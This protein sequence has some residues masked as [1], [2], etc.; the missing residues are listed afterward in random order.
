[1]TNI[2]VNESTI[3]S[4]VNS[5]HNNLVLESNY[6]N[7]TMKYISNN[8]TVLQNYEKTYIN[9]TFNNIKA[10]DVF[11]NDTMNTVDTNVTL[12]QTYTKTYLNAT[13]NNIKL[14]ENFIN[15]TL[16]SFNLNFTSKINILNTSIN[17]MNL[18]QSSYFNIVHSIV[19]NINFNATQRYKMEEVA[20]TFAYHFV[21]KSESLL[22]NG[23]DITAWLE[24]VAGQPVNSTTLVKSVWDNLTVQYMNMTDRYAI[25]P[26]LLS[27][28][29]YS[30][31]FFLPLNKT[32]VQS[33]QNGGGN[34]EIS[35]F[36][37]F[38]SGSASNVAVGVVNPSNANLQNVKGVYASL[39]FT[40]GPV[41]SSPVPN[42][43][44]LVHEF[45]PEFVKVECRQHLHERIRVRNAGSVIIKTRDHHFIRFLVLRSRR[46]VSQAKHAN[47]DKQVHD[48]LDTPDS[49]R[50]KHVPCVTVMFPD[51]IDL[52]I[53]NLPAL[54][55]L[56]RLQIGVV[57][58]C[59]EL[60]V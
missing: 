8:I 17:S 3:H 24:N 25:K 55:I 5:T 4:V 15:T 27:Y 26:V 2:L 30:V 38:I 51:S 33:I 60:W 59:L 32:Q 44:W 52:V 42:N 46:P 47:T 54:L 37:P 43:V 56:L 11:I 14:Q 19:G 13:I 45:F 6:I 40:S 31:T 28:N 50:N 9:A 34:A 48:A 23:V 29:S 58:K 35:M 53:V 21:P 10:Q 41:F 36:A 7:T 49:F 1:M 57:K 20:G 18:N 22:S 12:L 39:G 16:H